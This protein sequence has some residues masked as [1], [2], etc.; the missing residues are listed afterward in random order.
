LIRLLVESERH[1]RPANQNRPPDQ[2][3]I[4][5]HQVDGLA[6]GLRKRTLLEDRAAR[7]HEIEKARGVDVLLE[8]VAR[9]RRLVD[10]ELLDLDLVLIQETPGVLARGSGRL[11]VEDRLGHQ[12]IVK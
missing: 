5:H 6:L 1:L 3:R 7:T 2:I 12:E 9:G 11:C 8:E 4:F 10:V